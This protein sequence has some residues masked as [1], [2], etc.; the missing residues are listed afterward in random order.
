MIPG[1]PFML[2]LAVVISGD[3]VSAFGYIISRE[4]QEDVERR[5]G[6]YAEGCRKKCTVLGGSMSGLPFRVYA[7]QVLGAIFVL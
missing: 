3:T 5:P 4:K 1:F 7:V 2:A 6:P